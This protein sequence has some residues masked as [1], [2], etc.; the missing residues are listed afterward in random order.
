VV[1]DNS[2]TFRYD[3]D[4][5]LVVSEVNPER[6]SNRPRGIIANPNCSTMQLM[7]ALAPIHRRRR[8][9]AHQRR[10]LPVGVGRRS[11]RAGGAG[12]ADRASC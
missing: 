3:D 5:P 10:D 4:V 8:H 9:R 7:V 11:L 6:S 1:I 12:Q 2:S